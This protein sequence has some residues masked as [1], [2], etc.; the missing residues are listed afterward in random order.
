MFSCSFISLAYILKTKLY[1]GIGTLPGEMLATLEYLD[2]G[3]NTWWQNIR[4]R[5]K[6]HAW[7]KGFPSCVHL[8]E[9]DS[10]CLGQH[11][12]VHG[13]AT[14]EVKLPSQA[15]K[16]AFGC[17]IDMG[18]QDNNLPLLQWTKFISVQP[19]DANYWYRSLPPVISNPLGNPCFNPSLP[20]S[21]PVGKGNY[22]LQREPHFSWKN[23]AWETV[24]KRERG[25]A[26]VTDDGEL[27]HAANLLGG[28]GEHFTC[29]DICFD[30]CKMKA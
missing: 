21:L 25:N 17:E 20:L 1:T 19:S 4:Q 12:S 3:S 22:I 8:F 16:I 18:C 26:G 9:E 23:G 6:Q 14:H 29:F 2:K 24:I 5:S 10:E 27:N 30:N 11:K 13:T 28:W 7:R 15:M